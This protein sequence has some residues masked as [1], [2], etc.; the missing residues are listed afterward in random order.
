MGYNVENVKILTKEF[1]NEN[2]NDVHPNYTKDK[3][4]T[5]TRY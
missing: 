3:D 5:P 4:T 1:R 2:S